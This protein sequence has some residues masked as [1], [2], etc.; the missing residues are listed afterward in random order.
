MGL[1]KHSAPSKILGQ[2]VF[3]KIVTELRSLRYGIVLR[4]E[5]HPKVNVDRNVV[6]S[7]LPR[8]TYPL[9]GAVCTLCKKIT[10]KGLQRAFA[11]L[12]SRT[13]GRI[14]MKFGMCFTPP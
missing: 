6:G 5:Y 4:Y 1:R 7:A 14:S 12:K 8:V 13:A 9:R 3:K 10:C 11:R 2:K